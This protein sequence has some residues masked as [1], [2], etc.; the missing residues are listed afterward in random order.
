MKNNLY[1]DKYINQ[2]IKDNYFQRNNILIS[3]INFLYSEE[4]IDSI[5]VNA[6]WGT[7]K[8]IFCHQIQYIVNNI[9]KES[10]LSFKKQINN[11]NDNI[12]IKIFYFNSWENDSI[13]APALSLLYNLLQDDTFIDPDVKNKLKDITFKTGDMLLKIISR[14][15]LSLENKRSSDILDDIFLNNNI[16]SKINKTIEDFISINNLNK[17]IIVIDELDRCRPNYAVEMLETIKH[18]F[19][20]ENIIFIFS[21]DLSQISN[22]IKKFYGNNFDSDLYLQRFFDR[23]ITLDTPDIEYFIS[24]ELKFD[25]EKSELCISLAQHIIHYYHFSVRETITFITAFKRIL[26]SISNKHGNIYIRISYHFFVTLGI[27]LKTNNISLYMDYIQGKL[28]KSYF[29]EL[30]KDNPTILPILLQA[31]GKLASSDAIDTLYTLYTDIFSFTKNK[32]DYFTIN[33]NQSIKNL[34]KYEI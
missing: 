9:K 34:I 28:T 14:G 5:C 15:T 30:I 23:I 6:P 2:T 4:K 33:E 21:T 17:L 8:T 32:L 26:P 25:I 24:N 20:N 11:F 29:S 7:G 12:N 1:T 31:F 27:A 16:H 13:N 19:C 18:F 22:T 10:H 3:L